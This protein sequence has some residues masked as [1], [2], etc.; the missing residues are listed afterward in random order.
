MAQAVRSSGLVQ[1]CRNNKSRTSTNHVDEHEHLRVKTS[2][3]TRTTFWFHERVVSGN[4][5]QHAMRVHGTQFAHIVQDQTEQIRHIVSR[6]G[7]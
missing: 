4:S 2:G 6:V 5:S 1:A 7:F 3:Q